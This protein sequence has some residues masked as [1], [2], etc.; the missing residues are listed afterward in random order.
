MSY[1]IFGEPS[2]FNAPNFIFD[3]IIR[4]SEGITWE[5]LVEVNEILTYYRNEYGIDSVI[6]KQKEQA[7]QSDQ[8]DVPK[9][10]V[11]QG[12]YCLYLGD[13]TNEHNGSILMKKANGW[14]TEVGTTRTKEYQLKV[15][16]NTGTL[17]LGGVTEELE[18]E[19]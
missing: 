11:F 9:D 10:G 14:Y 1:G 3:R 8:R 18:L 15:D 13:A 6:Y 5:S 16:E 4:E 17:Y 2:A 7:Y 19:E 12:R